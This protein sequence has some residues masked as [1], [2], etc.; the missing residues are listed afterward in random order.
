MKGKVII[1][2]FAGIVGLASV[3]FAQPFDAKLQ[4]AV[5]NTKLVQAMDEC[6]TPTTVISGQGAC[7]PAN[8]VTDGT[9]FSVGKLLVKNKLG[10]SQ[11]L[12]LLK[13][14]SNAANKNGLAG[15]NLRVRLTLRITQSGATPAT[16]AD[17]TVNCGNATPVPSN[18]NYLLKTQL[19][20]CAL[21]SALAADG[22]LKEIVSASIVDFTTGEAI[23]VPGVRKK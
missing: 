14:S 12:G 1:G 17:I 3:A 20:A 11:I 22:T 2:G 21:P 19:T 10:N 23:A 15:K 18:G 6:D 13:S 16:F 7:V 9:D 8:V 4:A 5:Y